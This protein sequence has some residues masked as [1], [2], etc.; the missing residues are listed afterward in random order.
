MWRARRGEASP[1]GAPPGPRK[2]AGGKGGLSADRVDTGADEVRGI[3]GGL[4]RGRV[5]QIQESSQRGG[6]ARDVAAGR[7][8]AKGVELVFDR[9][10]HA[11]G[12]GA[13]EAGSR[14]FEIALDQPLVVP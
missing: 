12:P 6:T 13:T 2:V 11:T 5:R 9:Q 1:T 14:D 3:K 10:G 7:I 4:Q 8:P